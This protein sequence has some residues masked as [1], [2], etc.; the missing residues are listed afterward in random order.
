MKR[1]RELFLARAAMTLALMV[2]TATTA[3]ADAVTLTED[4]DETAGTAA[5]WYVNIPATDWNWLTLADA[6]ITSF[7]VYDD[8]GKSSGYSY[9]DHKLTLKAPEGYVLQLSGNIT[10]SWGIDWL[11][12][13]DDSY[14][15]SSAKLLNEVY[16]SS[17]GIETPITTV[18]SSGQYMT[19]YFH[20]A[21]QNPNNYAGLDLTVTLINT[22]EE[23]FN[24]T[25][26]NPAT[27]GTV[28]SDKATARKDETVT[29]AHGST[30]NREYTT[31]WTENVLEL[32]NGT[33]NA[34]II[35][36]A[37]ATGKTY[38]R[39]TLADRTLLKD[40]NWNTLC[41]PFDV[42]IADSPLAGD[43][44]VAKVFDNT[45]SM[46]DAGVLTLKFTAAPA[47][48]PAGTPFIIKW[49][50]TGVNLV[51]PVFSGVSISSTPAQEVE[52]TDENV[53]F[54]GQY[55]PFAIT[56]DN[57]KE[58][59]FVGTGN[60]IGYSASTRTL[61]SFRAHFWVKPNDGAGARSINI[62]FGDGETTSLNEELRVK[63]EE[64]ATAQ[65]YTLDGRRLSGKPTEKGVY[66]N[67][68][69]KVMIK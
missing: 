32:A 11:S 53:Q 46:S 7:K 9:G 27:G 54:V 29:I 2:L 39:V 17:H 30:G 68:G 8:G 45:S 16:S 6:T 55:S 65:W 40:G 60:K 64:F 56:D 25:V 36:D 41:L 50:N 31:T 57:I 52:S 35:A 1:K 26:N 28:S 34:D 47:T 5:R 20:S 15:N 49:D 69:K 19:L 67:N 24:I 37:A 21:S 10:T 33:S 61:K 44:V 13:A 22:N 4:T 51:N 62:D 14:F 42:T 58:I 38:N 43:G 63:N 59:L 12:V 3:W 48:I 18:N 66:I 23:A